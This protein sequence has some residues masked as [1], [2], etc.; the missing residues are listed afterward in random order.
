MTLSI[1]GRLH[2]SV[3][4][5]ALGMPSQRVVVTI[6]PLRS[7]DR[8]ALL[9]FTDGMQKARRRKSVREPTSTFLTFGTE[10]PPSSESIFYSVSPLMHFILTRVL[11]S[12]TSFLGSRMC[13]NFNLKME[14]A[15]FVQCL[16]RFPLTRAI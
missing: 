1:V 9:R 11:T 4:S 10:Q 7:A 14:A 5:D 13:T 16:T 12:H 6:T 2:H 15:P 8:D 3:F